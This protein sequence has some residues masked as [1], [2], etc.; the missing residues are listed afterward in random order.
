MTNWTNR[1]FLI[2][3]EAI[4]LKILRTFLCGARTGSH[5]WANISLNCIAKLAHGKHLNTANHIDHNTH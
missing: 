5:E 2:Y 1:T 4:C 3:S